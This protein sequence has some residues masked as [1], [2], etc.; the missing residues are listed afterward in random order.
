MEKVIHFLLIALL[1]IFMLKCLF[2]GYQPDNQIIFVTVA[3]TAIY[4]LQ[5][6]V[7]E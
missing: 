2:T 3:L 1:L 6:K 5:K 4:Q 7:R